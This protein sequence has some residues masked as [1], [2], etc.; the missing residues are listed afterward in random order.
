MDDVKNTA[1][2][3]LSPVEAQPVVVPVLP[4]DPNA[5]LT[6]EERDAADSRLIRRLDWNLLPWLCILYLLAFLDR[7]NIGNAKISGLENGTHLVGDQYNISL[8]IFFIPYSL[9]LEPVTNVIL[10][11]WRPSVFIPIIIFGGLAAARWFLGLAECGLFPGVNYYL[12]CWYKRS[13]FG[14]RAAIFFS[15]AALAG[16]FGGLLAAGIERMDGIGNL[17]GWRWIFIL[18]GLLTIVFGVASFWMVYDFPAEA[19]FLTDAD[20]ARVIHRLSLD[21]QSSAEPEEWSM[22]HVRA[23]LRD[24]KT[25]LGMFIYAGCLMPVYALSLF[26][27]SIIREL[28]MSQDVVRNQ[29]LTVPPYA[30]GASLTVLVGFLADKTRQRGIWNIIV[31]CFGIAGFA[32]L[33]GSKDPTVQYAGT[34]LG[35]AGVVIGWGNLNGIVSS[36]IYRH[37]PRYLE[38]HGIVL[39]YLV[40]FLFGG[41][42]LMRL[43]LQVENKKRREGL[44]DHMAQGRDYHEFAALGDQ[45]P[46]FYYTV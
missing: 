29:L 32:M 33:L 34:F 30:V 14:T 22:K 18:E 8:T 46:D 23:A 2:K 31:S 11:K 42:I 4:P 6:Q 12:S 36:N 15:S 17:E 19:R 21:Q 20:R 41:S 9:C 26:L 38:G 45:R 7:T 28:G 10:K 5:H 35:A 44:R 37:A 40:I 3:Q 13:E 25:W 1:F 39:G 43:M 24:W 27:P 16:S